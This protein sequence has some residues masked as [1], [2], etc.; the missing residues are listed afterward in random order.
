MPNGV[1]KHNKIPVCRKCENIIW[2]PPSE[3]SENLT[4]QQMIEN[5][6]P[7]KV[8]SKRERSNSEDLN[9]KSDNMSIMGNTS[10][11]NEDNSEEEKFSNKILIR[12]QEPLKALPMPFCYT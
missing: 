10:E 4:I 8:K 9:N 1:P 5:Y 11:R 7:E 2:R 12:I 6:Y 3:M